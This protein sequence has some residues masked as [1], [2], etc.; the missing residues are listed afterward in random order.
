M[1][2]RAM[3]LGLIVPSSNTVMEPDLYRNLPPH[4]TLHTAR[5]YLKETTPAGELAMVDRV[6]QA[7]VDIGT[8]SPDLIVF[9]CTSAGALLGEVGETR[10]MAQIRAS[11]GGAPVLTVIGAVRAVLRARGWRRAAVLTPYV[12]ELNGPIRWSVEGAGV[13]VAS[14]SGLGLRDNLDI[15]KVQPGAI[16]S[17]AA[18]EMRDAA[19][20]GVFLSCTNFQALDALEVLEH[21]LGLPCISS[22][23]C[24]L[25]VV[26][27]RLGQ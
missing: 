1:D 7:A 6:E 15:G 10:L 16:V 17:W 5:M 20:D 3:R 18:N 4:I 22:N 26:A 23:S 12:E 2:H 25:E 11:A 13:E 8:V 19:V 24:V 9:G 21:R 14:I 27:G